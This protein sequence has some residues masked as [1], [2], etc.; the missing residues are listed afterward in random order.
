MINNK[1]RVN[2]F[3][4]IKNMTE[5]GKMAYNTAEVNYFGENNYKINMKVNLKRV[6]VKERENNKYKDNLHILETL[7]KIKCKDLAK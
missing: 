5:N 6:N 4:K 7:F 1:E 3:K 2:I